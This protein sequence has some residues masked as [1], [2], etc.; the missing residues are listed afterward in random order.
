MLFAAINFRNGFPTASWGCFHPL[1]SSPTVRAGGALGYWI[2]LRC[3]NKL[4]GVLFYRII[5]LALLVT[6]L[7]LIVDGSMPFLS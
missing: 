4:D 2:G 3:L 1:P 6:G 7:K 5:N